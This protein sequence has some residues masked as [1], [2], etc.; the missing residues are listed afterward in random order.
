MESTTLLKKSYMESVYGRRN[1]SNSWINSLIKAVKGEKNNE[2][3]KKVCAEPAISLY[4][5]HVSLVQ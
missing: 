4:S 5:H 3:D 2:N 1:V